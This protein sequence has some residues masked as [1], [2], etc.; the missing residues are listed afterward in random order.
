MGIQREIG[1][2]T[3]VTVSYIGNH[4]TKLLRGLDINQMILQQNGFLADYLRA[5]SNGFLSLAA[6]N[7]KTFD[8]TFNPNIAGSQPLTVLPVVAAAAQS[9]PAIWGRGA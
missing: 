2:H 8:P 6:T 5:R 3:V 7:G 9:I 1:W 4:G